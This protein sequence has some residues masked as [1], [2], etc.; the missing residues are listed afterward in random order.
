MKKNFNVYSFYK[1]INNTLFSLLFIII[2]IPKIY[3]YN[4]SGFDNIY[5]SANIT[6][7][8]KGT[9]AKNILKYLEEKNSTNKI[10]INYNETTI[11]DTNDLM[12]D[13]KYSIDFFLDENDIDCTYIFE[14]CAY[15]LEIKFINLDISPTSSLDNMF[16][17]CTLL[18][19]LDLTNLHTSNVRSMQNMFKGCELLTYLD[20]SNFNILQNI[21]M[22]NIFKDCSNL[23]FIKLN[24]FQ[25]LIS[26]DY[27]NFINEIQ[28]NIFII[29]NKN[30][31]I[32]QHKIENE[33][34]KYYK[35]D[36][37]NEKQS[38]RIEK[39]S[40]TCSDICKGNISYLIG[41]SD[42]NNTNS[43]NYEKEKYICKIIA[44]ELELCNKDNNNNIERDFLDCY[45]ENNTKEYYLDQFN[46]MYKK[47]YYTC[48]VCNNEG[49]N[50]NYI[51]KGIN[52]M[53]NISCY[54]D[55]SFFNYSDNEK[56]Y[57]C[58]LNY[59][60]PDEYSILKA[61]KFECLANDFNYLIQNINEIKINNGNNKNKYYYNTILNTIETIITSKNYNTSRIDNGENEIIFLD[62]ITIIFKTIDNPYNN[63]NYNFTKIDFGECKNYFKKNFNISEIYLKQIE[64]EQEGFNV[65]KVEY[66]IYARSPNSHLKKLNILSCTNKMTLSIPI[67]ITE[68]LDKLNMSS[69]YYN[70]I[71]YTATSDSGT[72]II[73]ED[74]QN[75]FKEDKNIICQEDCFFSNY[76][77]ETEEASCYCDAKESSD[78]IENMN[79]DLEKIYKNFIDINNIANIQIMKC[80]KILFS[81]KGIIYNILFY[82]SIVIIIFHLLSIFIFYKYNIN[83]L[84]EKIEEIIYGINNW[85]LVKEFER[86]KKVPK[87]EP[88][89]GPKKEPIKEKIITLQKDSNIKI[90]KP[91]KI[92]QLKI[93]L[94]KEKRTSFYSY[95]EHLISKDNPPIKNKNESKINL[96]NEINSNCQF[97]S[98]NSKSMNKMEIIKKAK[99]IM[100]YNDD[101][102]N[103][104]SYKLA[105]EY[106]KRTYC[107]YYLSLI[108]TKHILIFSFYN[109]ENDYN[110]QII[111]MDLF[112]IG[113]IIDV[114]INALFFS[115]DTMHKIYEDEGD[116]NFIYQ[117]PQ[118]IYSTLISTALNI[119]IQMLA[120]SE[121]TI[122]DFK[123]NKRKK[124]LNERVK[125][126]K[127][128]LR[129]KFILYFII[130]IILLIFFWYYLSMFCAIYSNT[131]NHLIK[132]TLISFG[133]SLIYPIGIYLLPGIFRIIALSGNKRKCIYK[134]CLILQ[135]I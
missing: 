34:K 64:I 98:K 80:Y 76:N 54:I 129:I 132:D 35:L 117:L 22:N 39:M 24:N 89:K 92:K 43:C 37:S 6:L 55:C 68:S 60:C 83:K 86:P 13:K 116:F 127:K 70:D 81:K 67:K 73:I 26:S 12:A 100:A 56:N 131:Q 32:V 72:D 15:I 122:L 8:I 57:Q 74:R 114:F 88:K 125:K 94:K 95:L 42:D 115:D 10:C 23:D 75:K 9:G 110:S 4:Y 87:K 85:N 44:L 66:D 84:R 3:N 27:E 112:F 40:Q 28:N 5:D 18:T 16:E 108:K 104:L 50:Y 119:L 17:G 48:E 69:P 126:L 71:C 29:G 7:L 30:I 19:S 106:D 82:F 38:N 53:D 78:S 62:K 47:C 33:T 120:L 41:Y 113:F 61:D 124:N 103:N 128:V 123:K 31:L 135:M 79:I 109:N 121:D 51:S 102:M 99:D 130:C 1:N 25:G 45:N 14:Q 101:E 134:I 65:K 107:E 97:E 133:L 2:I 63:I 20:L 58:N 11:N 77:Y 59:S 52:I 93:K 91:L 118:I 21:Q 111:K 90:Y 36:C 105:L 46:S 49:T 96:D